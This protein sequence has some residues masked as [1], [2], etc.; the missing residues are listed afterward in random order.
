MFNWAYSIILWV[1]LAALLLITGCATSHTYS[2]ETY[3]MNAKELC[4]DNV[5]RYDPNSGRFSC[6]RSK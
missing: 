6:H 3:M 5:R 4:D 1:A 2:S